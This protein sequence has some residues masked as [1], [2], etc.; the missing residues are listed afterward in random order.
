MPEALSD[1]GPPVP[2]IPPPAPKDA[3]FL[4]NPIW[5]PIARRGAARIE[6]NWASGALRAA[7][8]D[9][10]LR[11][12]DDKAHSAALRSVGPAVC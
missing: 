1:S 7:R 2:L 12:V 11:E 10:D 5:A 6:I 8:G 9:A 4:E 3:H